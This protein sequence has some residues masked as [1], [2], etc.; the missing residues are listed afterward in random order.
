MQALHKQISVQDLDHSA[1]QG[2]ACTLTLLA[3]LE[4]YFGKPNERIENIVSNMKCEKEKCAH[5]TH[6]K[7]LFLL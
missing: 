2:Q 3:T 4:K 7:T 5:T 6:E 1:L